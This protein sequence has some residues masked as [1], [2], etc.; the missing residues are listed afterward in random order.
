M[1]ADGPCVRG[2]GYEH[3]Y[4]CVAHTP[5]HTH[6]D[7]PEGAVGC[8]TW[9]ASLRPHDSTWAH[10]AENDPAGLYDDDWDPRVSGPDFA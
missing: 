6:S 7:F 8:V 5:N 10:T 9:Y 1:I 2:V 4:C 3:R